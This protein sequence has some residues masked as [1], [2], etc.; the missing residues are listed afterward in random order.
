MAAGSMDRPGAPAARAPP[1]QAERL[2][3]PLNFA[4]RFWRKALI[5]SL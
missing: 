2:Q 1:A 3:R 4:A 5:P